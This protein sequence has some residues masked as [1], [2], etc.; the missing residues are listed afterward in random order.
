MESKNRNLWILLIIGAVV[1]A[2]CCLAA[3]LAAFTGLAVFPFSGQSESGPTWRQER[4]AVREPVEA[5]ELEEIIAV[6]DMPAIEIDNFAGSVDVM[7]GPAGQ[8]TLN[9]TRRAPGALRLNDVQV[10][11]SEEGG[12][13]RIVT[14][15]PATLVAAQVQIEVTVPENAILVVDLGSGDVN[16]QGVKGGVDVETGAGTITGQDLAGGVSLLTG[17]GQIS[18]RNVLGSLG[19]E[20]GAGAIM[21]E[22]VE[23]S[24]NAHTGS[25]TINV[26]RAVGQVRL[27]SGVGTLEYR[28]TP[29]GECRFTTGT[30]TIILN[31]PADVNARVD[32]STGMG[33]VR[34]DLPV[35]GDV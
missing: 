8:V 34:V 27:D 29:Q 21:V 23:G 25:G 16:V 10:V 18:A 14:R 35:V 28:G 13:V 7:A 33:E 22:E 4:R 17:S 9:A 12:V 26:W 6:G 30:G 31:L 24:I 32:L 1:V 2:C 20:T 19:A 11:V 5:A 15:R 3:A